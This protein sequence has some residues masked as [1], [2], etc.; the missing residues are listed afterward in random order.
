LKTSLFSGAMG[1]RSKDR[2]RKSIIAEDL[3]SVP[4]FSSGTLSQSLRNASTPCLPSPGSSPPGFYRY[5]PY[6]GE[7]HYVP[8][9]TF[10]LLFVLFKT[11]L[12]TEIY[13]LSFDR[14]PAGMAHG[15]I[16]VAKRILYQILAGI[17][18]FRTCGAK[19][20]PPRGKS[21]PEQFVEEINHNDAD[22]QSY[23][24]LSFFTPN[25][26]SDDGSRTAAVCLSSGLC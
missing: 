5:W 26:F 25:D 4:S 21:F 12:T 6:P 23:Y 18:C 22:D 13:Y 14:R 9:S 8:S 1:N 10:F 7:N 16:G 20:S 19:C 17:G 24:H 15:N 11:F 2:F 3:P